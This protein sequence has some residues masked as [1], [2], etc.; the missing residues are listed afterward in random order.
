MRLLLLLMTMLFIISGCS[1]S[2]PKPAE[3]GSQPKEE[4]STSKAED[5]ETVE[6][7]EEV[8]ETNSVPAPTERTEPIP[9]GK[10]PWE[11]YN[12]YGNGEGIMDRVQN[13]EVLYLFSDAEALENEVLNFANAKSDKPKEW[14]HSVVMYFNQTV[15]EYHPEKA[16][17]FAKMKEVEDALL[18]GETGKLPNL[19]A[20]AKTLRGA[21]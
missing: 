7:P 20:E 21:N 9:E 14:W 5:T 16:D 15:S 8:V 3:E 11:V 18:A 6:E 13:G 2:D 17:Y 12:M 4:N 10:Y 19:I 1:S